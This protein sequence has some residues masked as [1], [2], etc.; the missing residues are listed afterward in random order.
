MVEQTVTP[1]TYYITVTGSGDP[2]LDGLFVPSVQPAKESE[3]G[4]MSS[5][6]YW[7]GKLA[8]D[9]ADKKS[10]REPSLSYSASYLSWRICRLDGHLA[11]ESKSDKDIPDADHVWTVYKKGTAPA[12][13][14]VVH[15]TD[16]RLDK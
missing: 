3:S 11:Y 1:N 9:R 16:P 2:E 6:G 4:N 10:A 5:L 13:T 7:N 12:P 14:V 15:K 8:W